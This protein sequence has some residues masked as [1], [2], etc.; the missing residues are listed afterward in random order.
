[1]GRAA[2]AFILLVAGTVWYAVAAED[3]QTDVCMREIKLVEAAYR[4]SPPKTESHKAID[5]TLRNARKW[6]GEGKFEE[7][8]AG[9]EM[10][11]FLCV[12]QK[13]CQKLLDDARRQ[14]QSSR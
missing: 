11:T 13:G 14:R 12:A 1:M 2:V 8:D 3:P 10:A 7:A 5:N 6:C 9:A 4:S